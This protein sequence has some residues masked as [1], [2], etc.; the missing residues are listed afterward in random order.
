MLTLEIRLNRLFELGHAR[1]QPARTVDDVAGA[2]SLRLGTAV[3]PLIIAEARAGQRDSLDDTVADALCEEFGV[4]GLY[5]SSSGA[6]DSEIERVDLLVQMYT[7]IR[8]RDGHVAAR[9]HSELDIETIKATIAVLQG[10]E[11]APAESACP[12]AGA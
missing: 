7:L 8:D 4:P 3:D 10:G 12:S 9:G 2:V 1:Q 5:L 6:D 11:F